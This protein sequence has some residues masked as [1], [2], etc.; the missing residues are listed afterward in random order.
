MNTRLLGMLFLLSLLIQ[1][2]SLLVILFTLNAKRYITKTDNREPFKE[3]AIYIKS[4]T[5]PDI[6]VINLEATH[7]FESRYYGLKAPIYISEGQIPYYIGTVILEKEDTITTLPERQFLLT[8]TDS[9]EQTNLPG[10]RYLSKKT[11]G[12]IKV[13]KFIKDGETK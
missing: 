3:L 11:F 6:A 1:L 13:L 5:S 12:N 4:Q 7:I 9:S 10:Y 8:I 2:L